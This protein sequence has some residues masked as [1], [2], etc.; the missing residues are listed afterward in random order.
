MRKIAH[1]VLPRDVADGVAE[2]V[3]PEG[4]QGAEDET[5]GPAGV[6]DVEPVRLR[7]REQRGRQRVDD[8]LAGA[9]GQ[10]ENEA[11]QV[12]APV[13]RF[14][15]AADGKVHG[16]GRQGDDGRQDVE[17]EGD[18]HDAAVTPLIHHE[19]EGDDR[20]GEAPQ[21]GP[22]D[23][24]QLELREAVLLPPGAEETAADGEADAAGDQRQEAG[25]EEEH[26]AARQ[27]RADGGIV[28]RS[29]DRRRGR[30][31]CG[32]N[33]L[34]PRPAAGLDFVTSWIH[35]CNAPLVW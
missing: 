20:D 30:R 26:V 4:D 33:V 3:K 1:R 16:R 23:L 32:P 2:V 17:R 35:D 12:E 8:G 29:A 11:A 34:R 14:L 21:A 27:H 15:V 28:R 7:A 18:G 10:R 9:V 13:S 5:S 24:A 22:G 31:R 19:A 6:E 25:V